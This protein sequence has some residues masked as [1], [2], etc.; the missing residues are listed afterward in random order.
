MWT[1]SFVDWLRIVHVPRWWYRLGSSIVLL[2]DVATGS[3]SPPKVNKIVR[4]KVSMVA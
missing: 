1:F 2:K 4:S 3:S